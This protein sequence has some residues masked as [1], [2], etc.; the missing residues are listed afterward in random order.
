MAIFFKLFL[1]HLSQ[2]VHCRRKCI[3]G[4]LAI[5]NSF[6]CII[7]AWWK[8]TNWGKSFPVK[9]IPLVWSE[10]GFFATKCL[11]ITLYNWL[12]RERKSSN[13]VIS[14]FL[15]ATSHA[16]NTI[17]SIAFD[18][19]IAAFTLYFEIKK[20]GYDRYLLSF[21]LCNFSRRPILLHEFSSAVDNPIRNSW[22]PSDWALASG[23]FLN[24]NAETARLIIWSLHLRQCCCALYTI[25]S[26]SG[27]AQI[28]SIKA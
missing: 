11:Y 9:I 28:W 25:L 14:E 27:S 4:R 2:K 12:V 13:E 18:C 16:L 6:G 21:I 10:F 3:Y 5:F 20:L 15:Y 26:A 22:L 23:F 19:L 8:I 1:K 17:N 7:K 24:K